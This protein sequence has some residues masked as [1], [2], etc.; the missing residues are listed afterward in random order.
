MKQ[1]DLNGLTSEEIASSLRNMSVQELQAAG[2]VLSL[3]QILELL[4]N[5]SEFRQIS[6]IFVG[7][8]YLKFMEILEFA[9]AKQ[10]DTLKQ[11]SINEP[12]QHHLANFCHAMNNI[13]TEK[14]H[15][16]EQLENRIKELI[17]EDIGEDDYLD[18]REQ[19]KELSNWVEHSVFLTNRALLVAWNTNR[20][21][22]IEKLNAIKEGCHKF[23][24]YLV[25]RPDSPKSAANG[26]YAILESQLNSVYGNPDN[27]EDVEALQDNEPAVDALV[28][29]SVWYLNDYWNIGL[30]PNIKSADEL[31]LGSKN[32]GERERNEHREK[33]FN[34]VQ[35]NL[36]K[37][38]LA[39][40][41][42]LKQ[43]HI[44][45][46]KTLLDYIKKHQHLIK[47]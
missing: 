27:P 3:P 30:L 4:N 6:P 5:P 13:L 12:V 18:L 34:T 19:I 42:D 46:K 38:G 7:I 43:A 8:S 14:F 28:K 32:F 31:D 37:I 2:Q 26:L 17:V 41:K 10:L 15:T 20:I 47:N 21:D 45:S 1:L 29:F 9:S 16:A 24:T 22:L 11:E 35:F 36:K 33:L 23:A 40:V 44:F 39:S 25:G